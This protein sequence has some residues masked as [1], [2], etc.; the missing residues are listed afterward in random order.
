MFLTKRSPLLGFVCFVGVSFAAVF[1]SIT[2][3]YTEGLG[4]AVRFP[5]ALQVAVWVSLPASPR[6]S[7]GTSWAMSWVFSLYVRNPDGF[8]WELGKCSFHIVF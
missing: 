2:Q 8:G 5:V 1:I 3:M 4:P 7:L 6:A